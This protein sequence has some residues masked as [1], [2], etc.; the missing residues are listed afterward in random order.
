MYNKIQILISLTFVV[1]LVS[2]NFF[3]INSVDNNVSAEPINLSGY[4]WSDNIGW[5]SLSSSVSPTYG[6]SIDSDTGEFS[7]YAWSDN[8]GWIDFAP[9]SGYPSPPNDGVNLE[10]NNTITGW[11]RAL[12]YG[13]GWDG[14]ISMNGSNYG[15]ELNPSTNNFS[16]YAWGADVVGW[17]NFNIEGLN[18]EGVSLEATFAQAFDDTAD[19]NENSFVNIN[20][21]SNDLGDGIEVDSVTNPSYGEIINNVSSIRYVNTGYGVGTDSFSYTIEDQYGNQSTANVIIT[22]Y[23]CGDGIIQLNESCDEGVNNGGCPA[24]CSSSCTINNNCPV[25]G[26]G[27]CEDYENF[28]NCPDD[29]SVTFEEF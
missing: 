25:C 18:T 21:L 12:S 10:P 15:I 22:I 24:V 1:L 6:V 17:V 9:T 13:D 14:W 27:V 8:I 16:G 23:D 20:S 29:C 2:I 26:D 4:A 7:G 3:S 19:V 11:A 28:V 5:I